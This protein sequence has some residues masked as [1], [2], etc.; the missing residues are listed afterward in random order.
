MV[1]DDAVIIDSQRRHIDGEAVL[2]HEPKPCRD[3]SLFVAES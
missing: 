3:M 2:L 1:P